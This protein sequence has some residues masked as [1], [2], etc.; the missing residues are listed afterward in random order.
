MIARILVAAALFFG[1]MLAPAAAQFPT[2]AGT[3]AGSANT[4]TL[5]LPPQVLSYADL[6]S[7]IIIYNPGA[8][9]TGDAT[10][11]VN[12]F[13]SPPH[14]CK[15]NGAGTT[16]LVG[17]EI[18]TSQPIL[19]TYNSS[20]FVVLGP[21][22]LPTTASTVGNSSLGFNMPPNL[23]I[24]AT[25]S[26]NALTIAVVGNNGSN[27][28][29]SNP[30]LVAFRDATI[31]NGDPVF[32]SITGALS[33][34][35]ASTHTMGCQSS[36][37]FCRLRVYLANNAGTVALCAY[38]SVNSSGPSIVGINEQA[39]QSSASGTT[40]GSSAQTPYCSTSS[41]SNVA[42]REI[43]YIDIAES[44][45]GTW[46][47]G[48]TYVQLMGP[49]VKK[50]GDIVQHLV[51]STSSQTQ[52]STTSYVGGAPAV[53]ITPTSA[54]NLIHIQAIGTAALSGSDGTWQV[55]RASGGSGACTT[56]VG[57]T[58]P[59]SLSG[60]GVFSVTAD[61]YDAPNTSS[62]QTYEVCVKNSST[63][64]TTWCSTAAGT[65][66]C[67]LHVWEEMSA[68]EPANDNVAAELRMVG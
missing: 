34:T 68:L 16:T 63:N 59:L 24:N 55:F 43:G 25:V 11:N 28:S 26:T 51:V 42:V 49:G 1:A 65:P 19:L 60:V 31:A 37:I 23:Q 36:S 30:I 6:V 54:A 13:G 57:N 56:A 5:T 58:L 38:N 50:A 18:V 33:I 61:A 66:V 46:A 20:C 3:G 22:N 40:G 48:P 44:T 35:I 21:V 52:S 8:S 45:A 32:E 12:S 10:L 27:A 64:T 7:A 41:L 14:F 4:Q 47:T 17:G 62:Q 15:P 39:L 9:N 67:N 2:Y 53:S 29:A